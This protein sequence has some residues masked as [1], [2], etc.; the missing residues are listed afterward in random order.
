MT[1]DGIALTDEQRR[2]VEWDEGPLVVIAGA[3]TGKTRVIVERVV[4][5]LRTKGAADGVPPAPDHDPFAGPLLPEQ[6]LVLTYN[7]RAA[8]ELKDRLEA[9]LGAAAVAQAPGLELPQLLPPGPVGQRGGG[10]AQARTRMCSTGSARCCSSATSGRTFRCLPRRREQPELLARPVRRVHQPSQGRARHAGGPR[11]LRRARAPG[12][13]GPLR[14]VSS[15]RWPGSR[16]RGSSAR[17]RTSAG[18]YADFRRK[19]RA[20]ERGEDVGDFD[21][22]SVDKIADREARRTVGGTGKATPRKPVHEPTSGSRSTPSPTPTSSTGPRSRSCGSRSSALVY[23]AYQAELDRRGVARLRRADRRGHPAVQAAPEHPPPLPAPVP[24]P[25]GRRVPGREHRPDRAHRAPGPNPGS[26]GQRHG[27]R[28]RRPVDLPVPRRELRRVRGVRPALLAG[29]P[30]TTRTAQR[31]RPPARLRIEENFRSVEQVLDVA[32][33]LIATQP[34]PLRARQAPAG[35]CAD[36][37]S[38]VEL[39]RRARDRRTRRPRSSTPSSEPAGRRAGA[40]VGHRRALS[41]AQAPRGDRRPTP[42]R[43]HPVH[44]RRRA[45]AVRDAGD[46]RP[47]AEPP[48][49]RRPAPGRRA[50]A[51]DVGR[52]VAARRDRDPPGRPD[53]PLRPAA[54]HRGDPRGRRDRRRSQVDAMGEE[55]ATAE[56]RRRRAATASRRRPRAPAEADGPRGPGSRPVSSPVGRKTQ[57]VDVAPDTRAKLRRL[58]GRSTS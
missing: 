46:P 28:R 29:R 55:G 16:N 3:G 24:I 7:V 14:V 53:G 41:Q 47:G 9:A 34:H 50:R 12:L 38:P 15:A 19:E 2:I 43:G 57:R 40:L 32:N 35:R 42:R 48:R 13:R 11:R 22:A 37:A 56:T 21:F 45:V 36:P 27:R 51:D 6:V 26:A 5:L 49:H 25:P 58:L 54:R 23:R 33:R 39:D 52:P 4:H 31:R 20:D 18:A 8:K 30:R 10:R 1:E 17:P 44:G